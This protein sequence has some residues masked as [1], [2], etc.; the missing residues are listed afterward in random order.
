M[1]ALRSPWEIKIYK[2]GESTPVAPYFGP[3]TPASD[4]YD[5]DA[6][7][8][9]VYRDTTGQYELY[10][11][12]PSLIYSNDGKPFEESYKEKY[13]AITN[14]SN[15]YF[16]ISNGS[17]KPIKDRLSKAITSTL[18]TAGFEVGG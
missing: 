11:Y 2:N 8:N 18:E 5:M 7:T 6:S 13:A 16:V 3:W 14:L 1:T 9:L 12:N 17:I 4:I 10:L 15:Y